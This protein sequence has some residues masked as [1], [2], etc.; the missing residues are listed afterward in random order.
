MLND[1]L[2]ARALPALL[3]DGK[4]ALSPDEWQARRRELLDILETYEYGRM[5]GCVGETT[6]TEKRRDRTCA[7]VAVPV[8]LSCW[9]VIDEIQQARRAASARVSPSTMPVTRPA[10]G[11][12]TPARMMQPL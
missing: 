3:P 7:G 4:S 5:P 11:S 6:W 10:K 8:V 12:R 2:T 9:I 1:L